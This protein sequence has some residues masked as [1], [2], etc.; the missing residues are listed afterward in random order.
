[1]VFFYHPIS[2]QLSML[3]WHKWHM[4]QIP[5]PIFMLLDLLWKMLAV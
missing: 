3:L 4:W 2:F 5:S 1:V